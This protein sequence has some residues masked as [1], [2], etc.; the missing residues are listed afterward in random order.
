MHQIVI[1]K[2]EFTDQIDTH[3]TIRYSATRTEK[4]QPKSHQSPP[5]THKQNLAENLF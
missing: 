4:S 5:E 3:H 2:L 1:S